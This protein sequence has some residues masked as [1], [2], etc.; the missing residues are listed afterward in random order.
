MGK[1]AHYF[2]KSPEPERGPKVDPYL[3]AL[4]RQYGIGEGALGHGEAALDRLERAQMYAGTPYKRGIPTETAAH[5]RRLDKESKR[6][7]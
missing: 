6:A 1:G 5:V 7:D 3:R 4:E 2:G